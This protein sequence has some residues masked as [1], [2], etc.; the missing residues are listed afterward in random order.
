LDRDGTV[1][2]GNPHHVGTPASNTIDYSLNFQVSLNVEA[3]DSLKAA[4][5]F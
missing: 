3:V 5:A 1:I 4:L 2:G